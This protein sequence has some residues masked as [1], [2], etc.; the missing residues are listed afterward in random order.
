MLALHAIAARPIAARNAYIRYSGVLAAAGGGAG[1]SS[2][3]ATRI[4]SGNSTQAGLAS[5]NPGFKTTSASGDGTVGLATIVVSPSLRFAV[6]S[7]GGGGGVDGVGVGIRITAFVV[8]CGGLAGTA[9]LPIYLGRPGTQGAADD[10]AFPARVAGE[11]PIN[12]ERGAQPWADYS[13]PAAQS[14]VPASRAPSD[15]P[16]RATSRKASGASASTQRSASKT[17]PALRSADSSNDP[18]QQR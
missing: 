3:A 5:I 7:A 12:P 9:T 2:Y 14:V 4:G 13:R 11:T 17:G 8:T 10:L 1:A 16:N 18:G 6:A 15:D